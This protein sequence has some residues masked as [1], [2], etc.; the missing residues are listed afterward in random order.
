MSDL[1]QLC[2]QPTFL[3]NLALALAIA[4]MWR[5]R[6]ESRVKLWCV[7]I[8]FVLLGLA[9][10][11]VAGVL[12]QATL[13]ASIQ[14]LD[15][16]PDEAQAIVV[17]SGYA[18]SSTGEFKRPELGSDTLHRCELA[19]HLYPADGRIPIVT[20][21]GPVGGSASQPSI[22]ALMRDFLVQRGIDQANII[23][24][25]ASQNTY[26]NAVESCRLLK[27]RGIQRI[28]LVTDAEHMRRSAACFRK[29]GMEVTAAPTRFHLIGLEHT[30][31]DYLPNPREAGD[32]EMAF[33]EWLGI[34]YYWMRGRL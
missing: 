15:A 24:E 3:L 7:T 27:E 31:G 18:H 13:V 2:Q 12:L 19:A 30:L 22:A 23:V 8:P 26:E 1:F 17:L 28:V 10:T 20:S 14:P 33:R 11:R 34:A 21:G 5:K 16:L 32:F 6:V 29:Q 9:C 4:W 25:P